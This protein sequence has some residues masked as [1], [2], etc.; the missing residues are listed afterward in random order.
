MSVALAGAMQK[1]GT[2]Q[3]LSSWL[4]YAT[5]VSHPILILSVLFVVTSLLG[6][7]ITTKAAVAVTIPVAISVAQTMHLPLQPFILSVAFPA[8][9]NFITPI[10]YQTNLMVYGPGGYKFNDFIK[11]GTPLTIIYGI[12]TVLILSW[13]YGLI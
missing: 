8:A 10:G 5:G 13:T 6:A 2:D 7:Y 9:A 1:T 12:V 3:L 11:V 4:L